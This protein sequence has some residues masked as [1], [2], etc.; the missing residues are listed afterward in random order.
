[1]FK[2]LALNASIETARS[3][4]SGKGF[5]V[6]VQSES[7]STLISFGKLLGFCYTIL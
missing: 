1:M 5:A 7:L 2:Q 3:G 6:V 4:E